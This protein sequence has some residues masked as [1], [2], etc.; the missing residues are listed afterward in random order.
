[1]TSSTSTPYQP[2]LGQAFAFLSGIED[3]VLEQVTSAPELLSIAREKDVK[4]VLFEVGY[5]SEC[6]QIAVMPDGSGFCISDGD[7]FEIWPTHYKMGDQ[8][9]TDGFTPRFDDADASLDFDTLSQHPRDYQ[10]VSSLSGVH[11]WL[12]KIANEMPDPPEALRE[13][14]V[15]SDQDFQ[16]EDHDS[17][18]TA[19]SLICDLVASFIPHSFTLMI[20][21]K[22]DEGR[23][24]VQRAHEASMN[25]FLADLPASYCTDEERDAMYSGEAY[26]EVSNADNMGF[27]D[28]KTINGVLAW[29]S[30]RVL[31]QYG[32]PTGWS[33]EYNDGAHDRMS[34]YSANSHTIEVEKAM[35]NHQRVEASRRVRQYLE[36][37]ELLESFSLV[38]NRLGLSIPPQLKT[39]SAMA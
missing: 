14:V 19:Q 36:E 11:A 12:M 35:S 38:C 2:F 3:K 39:E 24:N 15:S 28:F 7:G 25:K 16:W 6:V 32:C 26:A 33:T 37:A 30:L 18:E 9:D 5:H 22:N 10:E 27:E 1:M 20:R 31:K 23:T 4:L 29:F 8:I 34:G 17:H 13:H 21:A